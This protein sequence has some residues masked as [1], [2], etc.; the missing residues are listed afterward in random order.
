[1]CDIISQEAE[2]VRHL[3]TFGITLDRIINRYAAIA[4][5][6]CDCW[7]DRA[8]GG[9]EASSSIIFRPSRWSGC[10]IKLSPA[11]PILFLISLFLSFR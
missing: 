9:T 2:L 3:S 4:I 7:S 6:T 8:T 11:Q 10:T 1:M 5:F